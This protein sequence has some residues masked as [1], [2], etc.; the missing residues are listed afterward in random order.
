MSSQMMLYNGNVE[1]GLQELASINT[2][3]LTSCDAIYLNANNYVKKNNDSSIYEH[4]CTTIKFYEAEGIIR[5]WNYPNSPHD[6]SDTI[7]LP[8]NDYNVFSEL[9]ETRIHDEGL[10]SVYKF[11]SDTAQEKASM[12]LDYKREYWDYAI[13]KMLNATQ[14]LLSPISQYSRDS[15]VTL[16]PYSYPK[17]KQPLV[18]NI[19]KIARVDTVGLGLLTSKDMKSLIKSSKDFRLFIG[20]CQ[21]QQDVLQD[22]KDLNADLE[23]FM[24]SLYKQYERNLPSLAKTILGLGFNVVGFLSVAPMAELLLNILSAGKDVIGEID[25]SVNFNKNKMLY[26]TSKLAKKTRKVVEKSQNN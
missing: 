25:S 15:E 24:Q 6:S 11:I 22:G 18:S 1:I 8:A 13:C 14:I 3:L 21:R 4:I 5:R 9:I 26:F 20:N 17:T 23:K 12:M 19:F 10:T 7:L 2:A 16:E